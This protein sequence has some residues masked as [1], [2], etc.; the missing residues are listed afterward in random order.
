MTTLFTLYQQGP[1]NRSTYAE[2]AG[3]QPT[4]RGRVIATADTLDGLAEAVAR[5]EHDNFRIYGPDGYICGRKS[6]YFAL[7]GEIKPERKFYILYQR[8]PDNRSTYPE[9]WGSTATSRGRVIATADTLDGLAEAVRRLGHDNFCIWNLAGYVCGG[10]SEYQSLLAEYI[11]V[12]AEEKAKAAEEDAKEDED[13][14]HLEMAAML[15]RHGDRFTGS[16]CEDEAASWEEHGF[17]VTEADKWCSVGFWDAAAAA[18]FRDAG[19]TPE[20]VAEAA[21]RI[22]SDEFTDG[23]P[24]YSVCNGDT[25]IRVLLAAVTK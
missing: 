5:L 23:N 14:A 24:I 8:G 20:Q 1:D 19:A 13:A 15:R 6:E 12:L 3:L 18:A 10:Q 11:E 9:C 21:E 17:T 25:P 16:N 4:S 22:A 2:C 7:V